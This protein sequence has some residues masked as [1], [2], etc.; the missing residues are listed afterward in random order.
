MT[1][2]TRTIPVQTRSNERLARLAKAAKEVIAER[3]RDR[4]TTADIAKR[5][6]SAIGTVYRYFPDRV[7]VL[8]YIYPDRDQAADKLARVE[9]FLTN[10]DEP[11][12]RARI[13]SAMEVI[14]E[15][16]EDEEA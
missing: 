13:R 6:G 16:Q 11:N 15:G 2:T 1:T 12:P 3:G 14:R 10:S 4:F 7:A 9:A 5:S 8:D